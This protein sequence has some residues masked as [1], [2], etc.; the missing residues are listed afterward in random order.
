VVEVAVVAAVEAE[1]EK[2]VEAV[3][4]VAEVAIPVEEAVAVLAEAEEAKAGGGTFSG[5]ITDRYYSPEEYASFSP[6]NMRQLFDI[7]NA[8]DTAR[9]VSAVNTAPI[10][11]ASTPQNGQL[12]AVN[13]GAMNQ[14]IQT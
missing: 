3:A 6:E 10:T 4:V 11:P 12:T 7:R 9:G 14:R 13:P 1:E 5:T 8:R 2:K